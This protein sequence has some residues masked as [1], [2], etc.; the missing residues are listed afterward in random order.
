MEVS[1]W[2]GKAGLRYKALE[3]VGPG[4][5]FSSDIPDLLQLQALIAKHPWTLGSLHAFRTTA[6]LGPS[7]RLTRLV[8]RPTDIGGSLA[9]RK[10]FPLAQ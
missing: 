9:S 8:H 2:V 7:D 1:R 6:F 5:G 4:S 10:Q 3:V